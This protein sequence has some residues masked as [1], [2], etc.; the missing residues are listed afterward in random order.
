MKA[1]GIA[2][3][4]IV[5]FP[6]IHLLTSSKSITTELP[7]VLF[8]FAERDLSVWHSIEPVLLLTLALS[9]FIHSLTLSKSTIFVPRILDVKVMVPSNF[10]VQL[11]R[12]LLS[13]NVSLE[14]TLVVSEGVWVWSTWDLYVSPAANLTCLT[15]FSLTKCT[16]RSVLLFRLRKSLPPSI[17][18][19]YMNLF[20]LETFFWTE[21]VDAAASSWLRPA[22]EM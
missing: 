19:Q 17:G 10:T 1:P 13:S 22:A 20:E 11:A 12:A 18:S 5:D 16:V 15:F 2:S 7:N 3:V 6:F 9:F 14:P 21:T 8:C 4:V